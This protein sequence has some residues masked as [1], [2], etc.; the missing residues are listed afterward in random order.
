[1]GDFIR[2][3]RS[4]SL[5]DADVQGRTVRGYAAVY[6]SPWNDALIEEMGYVEKIARGAFRKALGRAGNVPLLV[7]HEQ[8]SMLATTRNKSLR[9]KDEAKGLYFEADLAKTTLGDDTLAQ[10]KRGD[11]WGVS[12]GM[13]SDPSVDSSYS[14]QP[15]PPQRTINNI[16]R[17]LDVS[18]TFEPS[19]EA[20][21][22]EL[23][24]QGF[25]ALPM[26]E[27]FGGAEEQAEDAAGE[28]SSHDVSHFNRR[29]L[30]LEQAILEK[31]GVLP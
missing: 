26:Q 7:Q 21:T 29:R 18:L 5:V 23:R 24:S 25:V 12:Y 19:Y 16:Q 11:V 13:A 22:V 8:R 4:A 10:V 31:G 17:L 14:R 6:D 15:P 2:E 27:I 9:L 20:A 30:A 1:M 3:L 28:F